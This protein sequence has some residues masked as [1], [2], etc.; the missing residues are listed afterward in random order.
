[1]IDDQN[2]Q[3][4]NRLS[5]IDN[6]A[7]IE[8]NYRFNQK[9]WSDEVGVVIQFL[10]VYKSIVYMQLQNCKLLIVFQSLT[11]SKQTIRQE[12]DQIGDDGWLYYRP[13]L[14]SQK[15]IKGSIS[16]SK[17][18]CFQLIFHIRFGFPFQLQTPFLKIF[19]KYQ[20]FFEFNVHND[21]NSTMYQ[22]LFSFLVYVSLKTRQ[23]QYYLINQISNHFSYRPQIQFI[24]RPFYSQQY[25][26]TFFGILE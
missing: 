4:Y 8:W 20:R 2:D 9:Q 19:F 7:D 18:G 13:L 15:N 10:V 26:L 5:T 6:H 12:P 25:F 23:N 1:M 22:R 3:K 14:I 17:S 11:Q 24:Y 21:L 16:E